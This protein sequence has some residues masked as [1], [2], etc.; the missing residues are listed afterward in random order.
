[1]STRNDPNR[2]QPAKLRQNA[3]ERRARGGDAEQAARRSQGVVA[4]R[5]EPSRQGARRHGGGRR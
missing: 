1:M 4:P 5:A 2:Q 3:A